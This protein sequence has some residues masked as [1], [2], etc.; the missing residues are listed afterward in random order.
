MRL[1]EPEEGQMT[2]R[3]IVVPVDWDTH[4]VV[5]MVAILTAD[6]G[7]YE[8]L[9]IGAGARLALHSRC[10]VLVRAV[11]L[12]TDGSIRR[13]RVSSFAVL[14]WDDSDEHEIPA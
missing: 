3:G 13:V 11:S 1:D 8:V 5:R 12:Q 4:G 7:E 14:D 6:E 2:L 10:E 9:P